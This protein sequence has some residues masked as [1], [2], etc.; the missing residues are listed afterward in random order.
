[1]AQSDRYIP[2][3]RYNWLTP[4]YDPLLRRLM[5]EAELKRRLI[6]QAHVEP[7]HRVL[8]LGAGTATLTIMVKQSHP[9]AEVV[10][11]DGDPK[12]LAIGRAKAATAGVV[13]TLD[14]GLASQL[15][16]EDG[17]FARVLSSLMFHHLKREDKQR[18]L[19]EVWRVLRPGGELHILDFGKP[20]NAAMYLISLVFRWLEEAGD[21]IAG[22]LPEMLQ[23]AGFSNVGKSADYSTVFGT[24]SLYRGRKPP[25]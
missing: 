9:E 12:V 22:L 11:L 20:Q 23:Q 19:R 25:W 2:A 8:D 6:A 17:S 14:R 15:P 7:G 16:Y 3:L 18:A 13:I 21:N 24:L 1:M 4:L 10:G 5:P